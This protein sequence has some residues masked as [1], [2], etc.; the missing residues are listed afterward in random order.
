MIA[1]IVKSDRRQKQFITDASHEL[2]T[3]LTIISADVDLTVIALYIRPPSCGILHYYYTLK[4]SYISA[5]LRGNTAF[6]ATVFWQF[7]P[8]QIIDYGR[9]ILAFLIKAE[10]HDH[11]LTIH[12]TFPTQ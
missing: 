2:K 12:I 10:M 9:G 1:L 4:K 7:I 3:P 8:D 5:Y 6:I 11:A